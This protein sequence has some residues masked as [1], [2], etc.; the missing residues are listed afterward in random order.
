MIENLTIAFGLFATIDNVIVL[1]VGVL[2]GCI[3]GAIPGMTATMGVALALP[4]TFYMNPVTG[5]LLLLGVYKGEI[6]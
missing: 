2:V 1:F 6:Y 4:F 3:V 5:I